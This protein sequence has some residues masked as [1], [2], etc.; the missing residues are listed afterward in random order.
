[1]SELAA[2]VLRKIA[3][4]ACT[5]ARQG[6]III[7]FFEMTDYVNFSDASFEIFHS[8]L[9]DIKMPNALSKTDAEFVISPYY[10]NDDESDDF[11]TSNFPEY[12][13][14]IKTTEKLDKQMKELI[15]QQTTFTWNL[16][17]STD[18]SSVEQEV[19]S[20]N[21]TLS[22]FHLDLTQP[23]NLETPQISDSMIKAGPEEFAK[24][25]T[26]LINKSSGR[27]HTSLE[28]QK[29]FDLGKDFSNIFDY[30]VSGYTF[31]RIGFDS[32]NN[33][34]MT[35]VLEFSG[36]ID[37]IL[38]GKQLDHTES[39]S[40]KIM[41][42]NDS[43]VSE[44]AEYI[45]THYLFKYWDQINYTQYGN[46]ENFQMLLDNKSTNWEYEYEK[47]YGDTIVNGTSGDYQYNKNTD[48]ALHC[49]THGF[50]DGY[51]SLSAFG[52]FYLGDNYVN[53]IKI[54]SIA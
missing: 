26:T 15:G 24:N 31:G 19:A 13:F 8:K 45:Y 2:Q 30:C 21:V 46:P 42:P 3:T 47:V 44:V 22:F 29:Y 36:P 11:K 18:F 6:H 32:D 28:L 54:C 9:V 16:H 17:Q 27:T 37:L 51:Y 41:L 25:I 10:Y 39:V 50:A 53:E 5:T 14:T 1:M 35:L 52:D 7:I 34:Y 40:L 12:F 49:A 38:D 4:R 23:Q 48:N 33:P 20:S 43:W